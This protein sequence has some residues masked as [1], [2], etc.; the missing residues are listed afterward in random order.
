[1]KNNSSLENYVQPLDKIEIYSLME[2]LFPICRSITGDGVRKSLKIL[3]KIISLNIFEVRTGT[4]VFDWKVPNEWNIKD[5]YIKDE[6]GEK[7]IDFK[8]NNLHVVGYSEPIDLILTLDDL[9]SH[10]HSIPSQ[11]NA[12]PYI[13]SYYSR[14]WGFC[15]TEH[16]RKSL[17]RGKYQVVLDWK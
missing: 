17:S 2:E 4:T 12:I 1:M 3:K 15:L 13:T 5:A 8:I 10:L 9:Q 16:Q 14:T 7:V 11:P 6:S